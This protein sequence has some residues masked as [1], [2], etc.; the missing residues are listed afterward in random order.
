MTVE[1]TRTPSDIKWLANELAAMAGEVERIDQEVKRLQ[2]RRRHLR[3]VQKALGGVAAMLAVPQL[4]EVV[5]PVRA[6]AHFRERGGLFGFVRAALQAAH[7]KAV[8]TLT[9]ADLVIQHFG[10]TFATPRARQRFL[11][12]SVGRTLNR[13]Y[14]RDEVER[15]HD[16]TADRHLPGIWR[17]KAGALT[18]KGLR[19]LS[20]EAEM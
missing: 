19:E 13:L 6:H 8:D 11:H 1:R 2:A 20:A 9:M 10:L 5:P 7:P 16:P 18:L 17:W 14:Q 15:L 4:S 3:I 12:D